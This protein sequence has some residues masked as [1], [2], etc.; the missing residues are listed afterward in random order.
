MKINKKN[1]G[2]EFF[3]L[4]IILIISIGLISAF[5]YSVS[6]SGNIP[7]YPGQTKDIQI[8]LKSTP[9]E[10]N[11]T[12]KVELVDSGG[13]ASLTDSN[14]EYSVSPGIAGDGI[15]NVRL[16]VA[17]DVVI[18]S[19]YPFSLK[20]AVV[21]GKGANMVNLAQSS[22]V[23][24]KAVVIEK[25]PVETPQGEGIGLIWWILGIVVVIAVILLI[26]FM[27]KSKKD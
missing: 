24:L 12:I 27:V 15:V 6:E 22:G 13:I 11:L 16:K 5:G 9:A 2:L 7:I 10:G 4:I 3:S 1:I 14:T 19:E 25:P 8:N 18:G 21:T 20:L 26:W 23:S 17:D